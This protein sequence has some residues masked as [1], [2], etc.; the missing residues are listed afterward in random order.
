MFK[1]F[2]VLFLSIMIAF[3]LAA[4]GKPDEKEAHKQVENFIYDLYGK[5]L[6]DFDK[7]NVEVAELKEN[8]FRVIGMYTARDY[9][10]EKATV[11]YR[12]DAIYNP[13]TKEWSFENIESHDYDV[14]KYRLGN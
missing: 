2:T 14:Y 3:T 12:V 5:D 6:Y 4:C 7:D 13:D 1:K 10:K 8:T 9:G 11:L